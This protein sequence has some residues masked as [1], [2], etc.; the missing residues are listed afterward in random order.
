M[1]AIQTA[2]VTL[3]HLSIEVGTPASDNTSRR[4]PTTTI[5]IINGLQNE[6][7]SERV[8]PKIV[9]CVSLT[10]AFILLILEACKTNAQK[11][12]ILGSHSLFLPRSPRCG[13]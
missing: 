3:S 13:P 7:Y 10:V 11:R 4:S 12:L 5:R 1:F 8:F 2:T 6:T 9:I